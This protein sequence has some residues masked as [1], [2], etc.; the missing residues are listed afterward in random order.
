MMIVIL[1]GIEA[2]E[3]FSDAV[4]TDFGKLGYILLSRAVF[5]NVITFN[6]QSDIPIKSFLLKA[7]ENVAESLN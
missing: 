4:D 7:I 5:T 2:L 3:N 6:A 1:F